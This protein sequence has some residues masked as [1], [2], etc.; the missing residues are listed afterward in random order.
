MARLTNGGIVG[1]LTTTPTVT[2]GV[3]KWNTSDQFIY[4]YQNIWSRPINQS[5]LVLHLDAANTSSYPG[6]GNTWYDLSPSGLNATGSSAITGQALQ[7]NQPYS[8]ASTSILNTDTHSIFFSV[9]INSTSGAWDRFFGYPAGGSDR[10]PGI[11]RYPNERTIHW[12][13]DPSNSGSDFGPTTTNDQFPI[14]T[15][16]YVGVTK[17][18][19][20]A[21]TYVNGVNTTTQAVSNPKTAGNAIIELYPYYAGS[22]KMRHVHVYNRVLSDAEVLANYNI[23]STQLV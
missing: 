7:N 13:Y 15:W 11:W 9:Q 22:S 10:S 16:Y 21:K 19:G 8:T 18:G 6:T 3:G 1:K 20:T 12:R 5:G 2:S 17:N 14:N 23:I 4:R